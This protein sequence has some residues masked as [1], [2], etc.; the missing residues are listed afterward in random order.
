MVGLSASVLS[1]ASR[2]PFSKAG[3]FPM[4]LSW[5]VT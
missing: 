2:D 4:V 1:V 3:S 5:H